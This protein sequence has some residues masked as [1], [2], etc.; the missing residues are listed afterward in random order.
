MP[1][2]CKNEINFWVD[3]WKED[4]IPMPLRLLQIV[5][6]MRETDKR[7]GERIKSMRLDDKKHKTTHYYSE[8]DSLTPLAFDFNSLIPYPEKFLQMDLDHAAMSKEDYAKKYPDANKNVL[9]KV[10]DYYHDGYNSGGYRWC[11]ENW[12]SKWNAVNP[13]WVPLHKTMYFDTA[14]APVFDIVGELHKLFP[15]VLIRYEW[16]ERGTGSMG[17]CEYIPESQ[18]DLSDL[19][20]RDTWLVEKGIKD[21]IDVTKELKWEA[22]KPY[23]QWSADYAGYKGG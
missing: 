17:G 12:G 5:E 20:T 16:Y 19:S 6:A 3:D 9:G 4:S 22:G 2:W 15:D 8:R 11:I 14:W 18:W 10:G 23:N 13:L 1:N 7:F 21:G